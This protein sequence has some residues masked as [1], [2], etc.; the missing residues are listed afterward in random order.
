MSQL[1]DYLKCPDRLDAI[2]W[3][4]VIVVM[5]GSILIAGI[6]VNKDNSCQNDVKQVTTTTQSKGE[7]L[8]DSDSDSSVLTLILVI[9]IAVLIL[10]MAYGEGQ[11]FNSIEK[12]WIG[13]LRLQPLIK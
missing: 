12:N 11:R 1:F 8:M 13:S 2:V 7:Q 6:Y 5:F 10:V 3:I 9:F 4:T